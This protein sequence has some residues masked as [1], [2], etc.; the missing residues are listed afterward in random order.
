[1]AR[2]HWLLELGPLVLVITSLWLKTLYFSVSLAGVWWAPEESLSDWIHA[3]PQLFPATLGALMVLLSPLPALPR[4]PRVFVALVIDLVTTSL[5]VTDMVYVAYYGDV[6]SVLNVTRAPMLGAVIP[7][8]VALLEPTHAVYYVDLVVATA[9]LPFYARACRNRPVLAARPAR[10][11]CL[12][13]L[14]AGLVLGIPTARV[15]WQDADTLFSF[16]SL[17]RDVCARLGLLPYHVADVVLHL[18]PHARPSE[19]DRQR[20]LDVLER[21][22]ERSS[23]PSGLFGTARG[24]NV[25]VVI[26]E[27]LQAFPVGLAV[28]GQPITPRITAFARESLHFVNF[29]EQTHLGTTA[30]A[31][32]VSLQSLHSLPVGVVAKHYHSNRYRSLATVLAAHGYSTFSAVAEPAEFWYMDRMHPALGFQRSYFESAYRIDERIGRWLADR[33]YFS[34][35]MPL[36]ETQR[37]PFMAYLLTSSNH[38]PWDL[39]AKHRVL[40]L[41]DLEMT[42]LGRYLHSVHYFD[43]AFG[44]FVDRLRETGLLDQS[45]LVL[46]GDHNAPVDRPDLV[47]F[48]GLSE[49]NESEYLLMRRKVPLIIR[50]PRG[51]AARASE[52]NGGQL[53]IAPTVL[54]LLGILDQDSV[55]LGR[56]LTLGEDSLVIFRDG[57]FTDGRSYLVNRFG[58]IENSRC[59]E[60]SRGQRIDCGPLEARRRQAREQLEVSDLIIRGDL[61]AGLKARSGALGPR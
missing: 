53:D 1:M 46:Y 5:V 31:E 4:I 28:S 56:D 18:G 34:Q 57:S 39:P 59:Y 10:G 49:R 21:T 33:E 22:R 27:S 20:V 15:A 55:M 43:S 40:S 16:T 58:P 19:A 24:A 41:G 54:A 51:E 44:H 45:I 26:A 32:F 25:I 6:L 9:L 47:R 36:L 29:H 30:D 42:S 38:H 60:I 35:T 50:L 17:H 14:G 11:V 7:S 8:I 61:I 2:P 23:R 3:H 13:L 37:R 52:V 12:T 48:F